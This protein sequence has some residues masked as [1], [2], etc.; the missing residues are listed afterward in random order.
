[1]HW[2]VI[3]PERG[4]H[5]Q[6]TGRQKGT[7]R[8]ALL[9][10][11]SDGQRAQ[12]PSPSA[13]NNSASGSPLP[14]ISSIPEISSVGILELASAQGNQSDA[15]DAWAAGDVS[16]GHSLVNY[17]P[18]QDANDAWASSAEMGLVYFPPDQ[19]SINEIPQPDA[20]DAWASSAEMGEVYL[21]SDQSLI[22]YIPQP[23]ASDAWASSLGMGEVYLPSDQSLINYI[24]QPAASD[25]WAS[26][27]GMGLVYFPP[28]QPSINEIPQPD[29]SDVWAS[30][31]AQ[32]LGD[33]N[34][35]SYLGND[36]SATVNMVDT[37]TRDSESTRKSQSD[38][39]A[40][41]RNT[42]GLMSVQRSA[43]TSRD[44]W[45]AQPAVNGN[46]VPPLLLC[47]SLQPQSHRNESE[48]GQYSRPLAVN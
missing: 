44:N 6:D 31:S 11:R 27:A 9:C 5:R 15:G 7:V 17:I 39:I 45:I 22:N 36:L 4:R 46:R 23:D 24:P 21:P 14:E 30:S 48:S 29:A 25:A 34:L 28:D 41:G 43:G 32:M 2:S 42:E 26:S 10:H 8:I 13:A 1:M 16:T 18:Q 3:T 35:G 33:I 40:F 19:P 47:S 20:N 38:S 12:C 37:S